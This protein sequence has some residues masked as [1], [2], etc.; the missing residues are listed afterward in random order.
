MSLRYSKLQ[1]KMYTSKKLVTPED[2]R[3]SRAKYVGVEKINI[4]IVK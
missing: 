4:N 2:G 1:N 3:D